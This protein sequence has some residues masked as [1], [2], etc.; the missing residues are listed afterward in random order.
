MKV[1][2][3]TVVFNCLF[4]KPIHLLALADS[5]T[6]GV[7]VAVA[8]AVAGHFS[9]PWIMEHAIPDP[10]GSWTRHP[11]RPAC[12]LETYRVRF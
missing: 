7:L 4:P 11:W 6:G 12:S 3:F 9:P 1:T 10:L 5:R 8:I 2:L